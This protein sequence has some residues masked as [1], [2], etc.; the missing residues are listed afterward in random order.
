[1]ATYIL[2]G[3]NL[4]L[5]DAKRVLEE[6]LSMQF[7]TRDSDY[8]GGEYFHACN[9]AGEDF[10]LKKNVD[11]YDGD[12]VEMKF[13]EFPTLLYINATARAQ[14]LKKIVEHTCGGFALLRYEDF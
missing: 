2:Y 10:E 7:K 4:S 12:P 14:E 5:G 1:M 9:V 8:Q 6:S 13:P 3:S 11:L